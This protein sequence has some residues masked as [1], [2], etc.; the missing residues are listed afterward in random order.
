MRR[1]DPVAADIVQQLQPPFRRQRREAMG[2]A[3][4]DDALG[5]VDPRHRWR[6]RQHGHLPRPRFQRA[7][8]VVEGGGSQADGGDVLALER[9]EVDSVG[10]MADEAA[11]IGRE[12]RGDAGLGL[13]LPAGRQDQLARR[14]GLG[15][16]VCMAKL[17]VEPVRRRPDRSQ[18]D[19]ILHRQGQ[20]L[21]VP[22]QIVHPHRARDLAESF[23]SHRAM[24]RLIP[25]AE[26]Q[27]GDAE[28]RPGQVVRAAQRVHAGIGDPRAFAPRLGFIQ[29]P[30]ALDPLAA[31]GKAH[32]QAEHAAAGDDHVADQPAIGGARLRHPALRRV[33]QQPQIAGEVGL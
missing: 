22:D 32:D 17:Q 23:P 27:V 31:E 20:H 16:P 13:P 29:H 4:V 24:L 9:G 2:E 15:A 25:G 30:Q 26:G 3:A 7:G 28:Y 19:A 11:E 10:S 21:P 12:G 14:G 5:L 33:V 1:R 18:L 8:G 6:A